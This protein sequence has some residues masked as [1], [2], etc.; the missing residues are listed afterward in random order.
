MNNTFSPDELHRYS[1]QIKLNELGLSGQEKLKNARVLCVGVGGLGSSSLLYLAAAGIG[2]L[3][4]IDHDHVELSNL[5]RQ[6]LYRLPHISHSKVASAKEEILLLNSDIQV[7]IYHEKI[8]EKNAAELINQYDII[9]DGSDNFYTNYLIHDTCFTH[10]KPYIYASISQFQGYCTLF[11]GKEGPCLRCLFPTPPDPKHIPSCDAGGVLG[12]VPGMLGIIQ[13]TEVIKWIVGI[14]DTLEKRLLMIDLLKMTFKEIQLVQQPNC[15]LCVHH[16]PLD[17]LIYPSAPQHCSNGNDHS[18]TSKDM[19][20]LLK[21]PTVT[22]V[23]VRTPEEHHAKNI[24]GKLIPL[25]ELS[26]RLHEL[27]REHTIILYCRS[28]VR[29]QQAVNILREA[30]FGS[31]KHLVDGMS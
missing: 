5:Q 9:V 10:K 14:G 24:G 7:D 11:T 3:G 13:A 26:S 28:G 25:S 31:V 29:S 22:L 27:N 16:Q 19:F 1:R 12:V 15:E 17:K 18:I 30:G 21:N 6:V 23:D 8:T 2:R 20:E 4:L